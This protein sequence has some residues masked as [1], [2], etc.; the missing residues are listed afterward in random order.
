MLGRTRARLSLHFNHNAIITSRF[1][2]KIYTD[3]RDQVNGAYL[4][5]IPVLRRTW[6]EATP[7]GKD[8]Y[9]ITRKT[10]ETHK[11]GK[12]GV[13]G[14]SLLDKAK[15]GLDLPNGRLQT[16]FTRAEAIGMLIALE[17]KFKHNGYRVSRKQ[18]F[19]NR[20]YTEQQIYK[21]QNPAPKAL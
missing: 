4:Y 2:R 9:K 16:E 1:E 6:A 5:S 18:P 20:R 3:V 17:S 21:D 12:G 19:K 11:E 10:L 13:D 8:K 7:I 14:G 15:M